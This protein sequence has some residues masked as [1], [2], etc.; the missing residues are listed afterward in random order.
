MLFSCIVYFSTPFLS[1][2]KNIPRLSDTIL[3]VCYWCNFIHVIALTA[4]NTKYKYWTVT[5]WINSLFS[6]SWTYSQLL[7]LLPRYL[8]LLNGKD[9]FPCLVDAEDHVVSFPPITN[10]ERTKVIYAKCMLRLFQ[11]LM[12]KVNGMINSWHVLFIY[13]QGHWKYVIKIKYN[14]KACE[15][16]MSYSYILNNANVYFIYLKENNYHGIC[17]NF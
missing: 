14:I 4:Q 8:Q 7:I 10:S 3:V 1:D 6:V 15:A 12:M 16:V 9:F 2:P 11:V 5:R 13:T 17:L